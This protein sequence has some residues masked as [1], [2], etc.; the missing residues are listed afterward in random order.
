MELTSLPKVEVQIIWK[1]RWPVAYLSGGDRL[2]SVNSSVALSGLT[3]EVCD[4]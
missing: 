1:W 3:D 4:P 2:S